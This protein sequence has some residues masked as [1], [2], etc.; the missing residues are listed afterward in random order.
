MSAARA[1]S[2]EYQRATGQPVRV[3]W[4]SPFRQMVCAEYVAWLEAE[5]KKAREK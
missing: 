5:L 2:A 4:Q 3:L 1:Y